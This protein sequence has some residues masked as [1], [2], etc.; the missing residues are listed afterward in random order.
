[1]GSNDVLT[2]NYYDNY[3]YSGAPTVPGT[4][5]GQDVSTAVKGMATGSWVRILTIPTETMGELSYTLYDKKGRPVRTHTDNYLGGY[6]EMDSKLDFMGKTLYTITRHKRTGSD[7]EI[8]A[9]DTFTYTAQDRLK[10]HTH[11]IDGGDVQLLADNTYDEL[12]QLKGKK[13]GGSATSYTPLQNVDYQYNIR[14]WLKSIN[15]TDGLISTDLG[16]KDDLFAFKI[17]YNNPTDNTKA[18]FN[19]NISETYWRTLYD[20]QQ[21]KY[22]YTYD[23]LNRLL[24]ADYSRPD[25][26]SV[27]N[28]YK[29]SVSYDKNGNIMEL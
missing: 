2:K 17:S 23:H 12:G 25:N 28:A 7:T 8:V 4:I 15:D 13:V 1:L 27:M 24:L 10:L 16:I 14:G 18:L 11:Q 26:A 9:I 3:S 29:E 20:D 5:E 22:T 6:T 19:G 21:R